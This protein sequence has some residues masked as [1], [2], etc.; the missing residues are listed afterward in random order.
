MTLLHGSRHAVSSCRRMLILR[1]VLHPINTLAAYCR[2]NWDSTWNFFHNLPNNDFDISGLADHISNRRTSIPASTITYFSEN[3][4]TR[5]HVNLFWSNR[6]Q[7]HRGLLKISVE[8]L[9]LAYDDVSSRISLSLPTLHAV[10][11][12]RTP[13]R[14]D[15]HALPKRQF[16]RNG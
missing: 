3:W 2:D 11:W 16:D 15:F 5:K 6:T 9:K 12:F 7:V 14:A 13:C 1:F 4:K 8:R 10:S